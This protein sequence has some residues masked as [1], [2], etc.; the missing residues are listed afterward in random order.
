M[1]KFILFLKD[2]Q[3][4]KKRELLTAASTFSRKQFLVFLSLF[5]ISIISGIAFITNINSKFLVEVPTRG[6][7]ITEGV[8]GYPTK[9]NPV[10]ANSN[11]DKDITAL[12]Y[13]GLT[14]KTP[15]GNFIGDLAENP[16]I[17]PD[18]KIYTF[19]I[20]KN[21]KFHDNK[22][23]TAD[24]VV[25]TIE[26][27][28]DPMTKSPRRNDWEGITV[29]KKDE[30]TVEFVLSQPLISFMD[31][32]TIGILPSHLWKNIKINEFEVS[33]LN[34]KPI[35]SGPYKIENVSKNKDGMSEKYF[36]T[37]FKKFTLG[38]PLIKKISIMSYAGEKELIKALLNNDIDQAG[39]ISPEKISEIEKNGFKTLTTGL[40]RI[41]G[42]FFN[43]NKNKIIT[44]PTV[45][46]AMNMAIDRQQI[47]DNVLFGYGQALEIPIPEKLLPVEE[48]I[49][50]NKNIE[51]ANILL[52][53]AGWKIG[54][55]GIRSKG[56]STS[57]TITKKVK[58]KTVTQTIKSNSP[59][60]RLSF[61]LTTGDDAELRK[62][63]SL[64]KDQ[65]AKIGVE[66]DIKRVYETG[67]L[68]QIIRARDYEALFFGLIINHESDLYSFWHS[69]Q[70]SDPG[71]NIGMYSNSKVDSLLESIQK[72]NSTENRSEK[73]IKLKDEF[74]NN[75]PSI[76]IYSPK[77][78]Y[79]T[80]K[81]LNN[82]ILS[83]L[84][85][86]SDRF[87]S[88]YLWSADTDKVWKI[89]TK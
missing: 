73:Y 30:K 82:F 57:K 65:L 70:R 22:Q 36:L 17:S 60:T 24:D 33:S 86:P 49:F 54:E 88:V 45:M 42:L 89:F 16:T 61:S 59:A 14:R 84:S 2:F 26:K 87:A 74:R 41:F 53:K 83:N 9:I 8:I 6:G 10:I 11:A 12:V 71:L 43:S 51:E 50:T 78:V 66:V 13:S 77:Y 52:E 80:S 44:E 7:S 69:S 32:T 67:Q 56:G 46:K 1:K 15:E 19:T 72:I 21:A 25:F 40:P 48:K 58:G 20:K 23:V 47:I 29:N 38:K 18:G 63:A 85:N 81:G 35:G 37:R 39:G 5:L 64:L 27:I 76:T 62:T 68:N 31:N 75:L 4:Y 3:F 28:K 79:I 34:I 55:D